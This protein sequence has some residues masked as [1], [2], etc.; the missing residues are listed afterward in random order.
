MIN[1]K[2]IFLAISGILIMVLEIALTINFIETKNNTMLV[3]ICAILLYVI[4]I[5]HI[6]IDEFKTFLMD[7]RNGPETSVLRL[8]SVHV[9]WGGGGR[10]ASYGYTLATFIDTDKDY[11][12]LSGNLSN[13]ELVGGEL[14]KVSFYRYSKTIVSIEDVNV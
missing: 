3:S 12:S 1:G 9:H 4:Y 11:I 14:Y 6:F 10:G 2:L 5:S 13:I 7:K 8:E